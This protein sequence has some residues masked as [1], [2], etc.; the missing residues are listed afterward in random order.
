MA[1]RT[2]AR[3]FDSVVMTGMHPIFAQALAPFVQPPKTRA[4]RKS[5]DTFHYCLAGVDLVCELDYQ[6]ASG[7]GWNEPHEPECADLCEAF[8]GDT[9]II[10]ILSDGQREEIEIAYLEQDRSDD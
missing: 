5:T 2:P 8:C 9:D 6:R 7:D 10:E 3:S 4:L 1:P